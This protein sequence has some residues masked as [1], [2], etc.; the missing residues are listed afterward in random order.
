MR[1]AVDTSHYGWYEK[2][3]AKLQADYDK[4]IQILIGGNA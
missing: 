3:Q 4:G 1:L 2:Q